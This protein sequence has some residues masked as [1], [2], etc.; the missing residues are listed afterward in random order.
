MDDLNAAVV[1]HPVEKASEG[2]FA[3]FYAVQVAQHTC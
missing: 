3:R 1:D 2:T